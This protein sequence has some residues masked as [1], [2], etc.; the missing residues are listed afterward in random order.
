MN[1]PIQATRSTQDSNQPPF[2]H[3]RWIIANN[4]H[5]SSRGLPRKNPDRTSSTIWFT[6][7]RR[8]NR[9]SVTASGR[10]KRDICWLPKT[11]RVCLLRHHQTSD[12]PLVEAMNVSWD[13]LEAVLG[14]LEPE[15]DFYPPVYRPADFPSSRQLNELRS[16]S[17]TS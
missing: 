7:R 13:R 16:T 5:C 10:K 4:V 9:R 8:S 17:P 6:N 12:H 3:C 11:D 2:Q 1:T 15:G 14:P